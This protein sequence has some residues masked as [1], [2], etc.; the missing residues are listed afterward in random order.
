[1]H[2]IDPDLATL[3]NAWASLPEEIRARILTIA[4]SAGP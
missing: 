2:S 3:I 4:G 1:M